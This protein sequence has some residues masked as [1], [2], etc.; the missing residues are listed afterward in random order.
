MDF[1]CVIFQLSSQRDTQYLEANVHRLISQVKDDFP[2][3][4]QTV[5][6]YHNEVVLL[7]SFQNASQRDQ[8]KSHLNRLIN[9]WMKANHIEISSGMGS[10]YHGVHLVRKSYQEAKIALSHMTTR[11]LSGLMSYTEIGINRLFVNQNIEEIKKFIQEI[12]VPLESPE[13]SNNLLK[14]TLL[15]YFSSNRSATK[16]AKKM[17]IHINT[18]YQ[19]LRKIEDLLE[20]SLKDPE[21]V[22]RLQLACYLKDSF[23][24]VKS[25]D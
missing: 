14:E 20:V 13:N 1:S 19:R 25:G 7:V 5:F 21:N 17:H 22:L 9:Q 3:F 16:T 24:A 10:T 11:N 2:I 4:I 8:F 15:A 12:F 6:G 23:K 18:L